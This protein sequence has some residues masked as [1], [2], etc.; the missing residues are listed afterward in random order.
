MALGDQ[1]SGFRVVG[2]VFRVQ[3]GFRRG[4]TGL[5]LCDSMGLGD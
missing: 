4:S 5:G 2:L 1:G 3:G